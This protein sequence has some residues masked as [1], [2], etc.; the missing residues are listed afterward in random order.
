MNWIVAI[1]SQFLIHDSA[2]PS[3]R[4]CLHKV[5]LWREYIPSVPIAFEW[6]DVGGFMGGFRSLYIE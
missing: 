1:L 2:V 4:E 6:P 5:L 3:N